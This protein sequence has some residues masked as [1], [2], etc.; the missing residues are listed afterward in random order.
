MGSVN[1]RQSGQSYGIKN[2]YGSYQAVLE[3]PAVDMVY[4]SVPNG[5][6]YEWPSKALSAGKHVL[7]EKPFTS[8]ATE[9]EALVK[10]A[11]E[12]GKVLMEAFH[13]QFHPAAHTSR[14]ILESGEH[15]AIVSINSVMTASPGVPH[16]D[17]RWHFDLAGGSTMN[18]TYALFL[19][20]YAIDAETPTDILSAVAKP[21]SRDPRV[22]TALISTMLFETPDGRTVY[23]RLYTDLA[24]S[25]IS[26]II[27]QVWEW[28]AIEVETEKSVSYFYNA[29]MPHL[30]HYISITDKASGKTTYRKQYS[31]GPI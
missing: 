11:S 2:A 6:H 28:P 22:D 3:D 7:L 30:Y 16:G 21:Y 26:G 24:R 19:T 15:G 14:A 27:P 17:I 31:G 13:W 8:N 25:W 9:G 12:S 29:M 4:V 18:C 20:R 10:Q 5:M 1:C 23:S